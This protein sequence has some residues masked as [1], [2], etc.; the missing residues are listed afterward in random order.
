MILPANFMINCKRLNMLD[1]SQNKIE[2]IPY[3][4][5]SNLIKINSL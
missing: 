2:I 4:F 5:L 1:L 3:N